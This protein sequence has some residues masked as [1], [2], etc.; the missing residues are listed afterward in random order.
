MALATATHR[1][2]AWQ[3]IAL[4]SVAFSGLFCTWILFRQRLRITI[5]TRAVILTAVVTRLIPLFAQPLFDDDYFRFLWD[6]YQLTLGAS[7]YAKAPAD[8]FN[9]TGI[10]EAW[11][12][13]LRQVNYPNV[14][15]IYGPSLQA[16]FAAAVW[17]GG[18]EVH[19]LKILFCSIDIALVVV[20][21]RAGIAPWLV[22]AY[23]VNPLAIKEIG[24]SLHPDGVIA[25]WLT[26]AVL[27]LNRAKSLWAGFF[28]ALAICAKLPLALLACSLNAKDRIHQRALLVAIIFVFAAYVPFVLGDSHPFSGLQTFS[29]H[30]RFNTLVF[31]A[32]EWL[33]GSH[34]RTALAI[35]YI[36]LGATCAAVVLRF[37]IDTAS[38]LTLFLAAI[39]VSSP[40]VNPWYWLP[41]L[42]LAAVAS[43]RSGTVLLAP[44]VGSFALLLGYSSAEP[45]QLIGLISATSSNQKFSV[46][47]FAR[48]LQFT[49]IASALIFDVVQLW[50][51][52][53]HANLCA[54]R[55][56]TIS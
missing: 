52:I 4:L 25:L 40:A 30:W 54:V 42:P 12:D 13:V 50:R 34:A 55:V 38:A 14:P 11:Q 44:W 2:R 15:T 41:V 56:A 31:T 36:G 21:T 7:P 10:S 1:D 47:P 29:Q 6:G 16:L 53:K 48:A 49:L 37:N 19:A 32:F 27:S 28:A 24:F 18:S 46:I 3:W 8:F 17:M 26:L 51:K 23:V 35:F 45:L 22:M 39:I 43:V 33:L 9:S 5:T 20:L